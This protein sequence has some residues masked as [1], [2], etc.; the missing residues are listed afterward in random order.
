MNQYF[1]FSARDNACINLYREMM[2]YFIEYEIIYN[3]INFS[4]YEFKLKTWFLQKM[5]FNVFFINKIKLFIQEIDKT[6]I[7]D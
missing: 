1:A 6:F 7:F 5:K 3:Y 4:L 2:S